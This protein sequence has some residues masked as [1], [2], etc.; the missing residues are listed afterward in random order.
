M[1]VSDQ[2]CHLVPTVTLGITRTV[3]LLKRSL[4][5]PD[6]RTKVIADQNLPQRSVNDRN[7]DHST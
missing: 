1:P 5:R 4:A 3:K 2:R 7:E 6:L